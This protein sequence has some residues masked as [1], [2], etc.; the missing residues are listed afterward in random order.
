[1]NIEP[2]G[3]MYPAHTEKEA[4]WE[5]ADYHAFRDYVNQPFSLVANV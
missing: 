2:I 1:M 3:S 5:H 4:P